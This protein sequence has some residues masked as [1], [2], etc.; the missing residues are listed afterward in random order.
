MSLIYAE[1]IEFENPT[2]MEDKQFKQ[3]ER[4][5]VMTKASDYFLSLDDKSKQRYK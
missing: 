3:T 2:I 4:F 1:K 5:L